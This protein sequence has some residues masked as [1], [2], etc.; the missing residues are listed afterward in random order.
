MEDKRLFVNPNGGAWKGGM[1]KD[2][3]DR[4]VQNGYYRDA[5]NINFM[6]NGDR[7]T[8]KNVKGNVER[9]Y[10]LSIGDNIC[11]GSF[12]DKAG[13]ALYVFVQNSRGNHQII[14]YGYSLITDTVTYIA[15]GVG[16]AFDFQKL[17]T[18][19]TLV[20]GRFL[21]W[22]QDDQEVGCIDLENTPV[23]DAITI[24]TANRWR[25][26]LYKT[27]DPKPLE[28]KFC[29]V[30][31]RNVN[32]LRGKLYKF[33]SVYIYEGGFRSHASTVSKIAIPEW[34]YVLTD[35]VSTYDNQIYMEVSLPE[36]DKV[37]RVDLFVQSGNNDDS[38]GNWLKFKEVTYAEINSNINDKLTVVF[39]GEETLESTDQTEIN[40]PQ[41]FIPKSCKDVVFLPSSVISFFNL[42]EGFD[43]DVDVAGQ[44]YPT[45]NTRN[46]TSPSPT[47]TSTFSTTPISVSGSFFNVNYNILLDT[48]LN[49]KRITI[50]GTAQFGD[51][52]TTSI[53]VSHT[54]TT[55]I[56]LANKTITFIYTVRKNDTLTTIASNI[57][58]VINSTD[59]RYLGFGGIIAYSVAG[60]VR[61]VYGVNQNDAPYTTSSNISA[62]TTTTVTSGT[63]NAFSSE[64]NFKRFRQHNFAIQYNSNGR[65]SSAIPFASFYSE[66]YD[67][68][69][70]KFYTTA[71]AVIE[72]LPPTDATSYDI[73]YAKNSPEFL[74]I[75]VTIYRVVDVPYSEGTGS[76]PSVGERI[77][78][79]LG[80]RGIVLE[81][82]NGSSVEGT[83]RVGLLD[84]DFTAGTI[85][86]NTSTWSATSE[87]QVDRGVS[88]VNLFDRID[89]DIDTYGSNSQNY[90]Y[91]VG[92]QIRLIS[93]GNPITYFSDIVSVPIS[94]VVG[95]YVFFN[96]DIR[97]LTPSIVNATEAFVEV[98][99]PPSNNQTVIYNEVG[100]T[101]PIVGGFHTGNTQN[102]T[103]SVGAIIELTDVGDTY[104]RRTRTPSDASRF[105]E[106]ND[107]SPKYFSAVTAAGRP[108]IESES[109]VKEISREGSISY[110]QPIVKDSETNGL[111]MVLDTSIVTKYGG[112]F[113]SIQK[114]VLRQ[115]K[116]LIVYFE[117]RV[118]SVGVFEELQKDSG[119]AITYQTSAILNGINFYAYDGGIG[120]NPESFSYR[121]TI[122]YFLSAKNN[123]VCRLSNDGITE[124]SNYG[125]LSWFNENLDVKSNFI[126]NLRAF[127]AYDERNGSYVLGLSS[128]ITADSVSNPITGEGESL[129]LH[130]PNIGN[131]DLTATEAY[132]YNGSS[133]QWT[134]VTI[135][136]L[137]VISNGVVQITWIGTPIATAVTAVIIPKAIDTLAF[138]EGA[139]AWVSFYD[140]TPE[141]MVTCG[142]DFASFKE[143]EL[144][145]H[146]K[147][148][149]RGSFYGTANSA[150]IEVPFNVSPTTEKIFTNIQQDSNN[151]WASPSNG[152]IYTPEGQQ[153]SLLSTDYYSFFNSR[154]SAGLL[155]D[156]NTPNLTYPLLEG[157]DLRSYCLIVKLSNN[158]TTETKL[159]Y[160]TVTSIQSDLSL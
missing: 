83:V 25:V 150:E 41:S 81:Y 124:I 28:P 33:R 135:I 17:I 121:D 151:V 80:T 97:S 87:N 84:G 65:R 36:H 99:R 14:K 102:Q 46:F 155:K 138:N 35:E 22:A 59:T 85:T 158:D 66:G 132:V 120:L 64:A 42:T 101:Y 78:R 37:V 58:S 108:N 61:L 141:N 145:I 7:F 39:T 2:S 110:S 117:D 57:S 23:S 62:S 55:P 160:V 9:S 142:V 67:N 18:G 111:S 13:Q 69:T 105:P 6:V 107:Y 93:E 10:I 148:N 146:N 122:Q 114:A 45:Y 72:S 16:L 144:W 4:Y 90:N 128:L 40:Q 44:V 19:I 75:A 133:N 48:T 123:A 31:T 130:I 15:A 1:D 50:S 95:D 34:G 47:T 71:T 115:N 52:I 98:Y 149:T 100:Q 56:T 63:A 8:V 154:F 119:G 157:D 134:L 51:L 82:I 26:E 43:S 103:A 109:G 129:H 140:F 136:V 76:R 96:Y 5:R 116:Q 112:Q 3:E 113:G 156:V 104:E 12:D 125:M 86:F 30:T 94:K 159:A 21:I 137:T 29:T 91:V 68:T 74:Q 89:Y 153:S 92:D 70:N 27:P 118:G 88:A 77:D 79:G 73:L 139:N 131:E 147:N 127:G 20:Y 49:Y 60:V 11:I 38:M 53:V 126:Q 32:S 54:G 143:G 24:T 152:D 106:A